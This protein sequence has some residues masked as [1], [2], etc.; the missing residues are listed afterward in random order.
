[1][2][3]FWVGGALAPPPPPRF[4]LN[5][6]VLMTKARRSTVNLGA[7]VAILAPRA[8]KAWSQLKSTSR[9]SH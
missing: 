2:V 9:H 6:D 8:T 1:L 5:E 4:L 3:F 7:L